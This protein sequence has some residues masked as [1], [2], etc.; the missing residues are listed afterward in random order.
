MRIQYSSL[1]PVQHPE[2][3]FA[4]SRQL[5]GNGDPPVPHLGRER[6]NLCFPAYW[7]CGLR[8]SD[9]ICKEK[10][11]RKISNIHLTDSLWR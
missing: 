1:D 2:L 4:H 10:V 7:Q 8:F 3:A 6:L 11:K 5:L 9:L